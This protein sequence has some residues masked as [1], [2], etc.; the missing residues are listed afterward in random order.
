MFISLMDFNIDIYSNLFSN[1]DSSI[2]SKYHKTY[3][4]TFKSK[5]Q[6]NLTKLINTVK[7]ERAL[8]KRIKNDKNNQ[9]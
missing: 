1:L 3:C 4:N 7:K 9:M 6:I 5:Y 8:L 2:K